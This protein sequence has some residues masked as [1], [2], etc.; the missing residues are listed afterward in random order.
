MV[1]FGLIFLTCQPTGAQNVGKRYY[2]GFGLAK[3]TRK[4]VPWLAVTMRSGKGEQKG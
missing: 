3:E 4:W 2:S 1:E